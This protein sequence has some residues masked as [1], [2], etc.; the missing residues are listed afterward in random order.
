MNNS[1]VRSKLPGDTITEGNFTDLETYGRVLYNGND[2]Y[3]NL[4][5]VME[6]PEFK[7]FFDNFFQDPH[8]IKTI[9]MFMNMYS[10]LSNKEFPLSGYQ[11][12]AIIKKTF[13][14]SD[15]RQQLVS[16]FCKQFDIIMEDYTSKSISSNGNIPE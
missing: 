10:E 16:W 14:N 3:R 13:D 15:S 11:K 5:N 1:C 2:F 8:H 9:F 12:I 4:T 6:H 7:I